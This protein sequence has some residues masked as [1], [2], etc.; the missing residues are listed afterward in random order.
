VEVGEVGGVWVLGGAGN[1]TAARGSMQRQRSNIPSSSSEVTFMHLDLSAASRAARVQQSTPFLPN[2]KKK[3]RDL[4]NREHKLIIR[5]CQVC[6]RMAGMCT[7]CRDF[8]G[9]VVGSPHPLLLPPTAM[10]AW[11]FSKKGRAWRQYNC[12]NGSIRP[13]PLPLCLYLRSTWRICVRYPCDMWIPFFVDCVRY[14]LPQHTHTYT[15]TRSQRDPAKNNM[16]SK[17][18]RESD[19]MVKPAGFDAAPGALTLTLTLTLRLA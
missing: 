2:R 6:G 1:G 11:T 17:C 10:Y 7:V 9:C 19:A 18:F 3:L 15:H 12:W 8:H 13:P 4:I 16:C 14:S 5:T